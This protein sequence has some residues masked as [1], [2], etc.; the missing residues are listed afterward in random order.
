MGNNEAILQRLRPIWAEMDEIR[1]RIERDFL[2]HSGPLPEG[3]PG[4]DPIA[5]RRLRER[6]KELGLD[7]D[8]LLR[9]VQPE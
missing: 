5:Y 3:S 4:F 8:E 1:T 6:L 9:R 7:S 2:R